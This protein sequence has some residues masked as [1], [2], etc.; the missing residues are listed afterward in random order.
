MAV[1]CSLED[2]YQG[3]VK[4]LKVKDR[5]SV[6][7]QQ[8]ILE[9]VYKVE[10]KPGYKAGTKVKFPASQEFP[11][12]VGFEIRETP[13]KYFVRRGDDLMWTAKLSARQVEKGVLIRVPLLDGT[14]LTLDSKKYH[15]AAGSK[16]PFAGKGMPITGKRSASQASHG[17]LIVKFEIN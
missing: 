11:R 9:K 8:T 2:L 5:F 3:K 7:S 4:N 14:T 15:I 17:D 10:V 12:P 1:D 16:I 13:H 6:G